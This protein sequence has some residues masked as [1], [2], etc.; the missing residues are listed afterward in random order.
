MDKCPHCGSRNI[1]RRYS[2]HR[3]YKWRCRNCNEV[4]RAPSRGVAIWIGVVAVVVVAAAVVLF[5]VQQGVIALPI[6]M[7]PSG[8]LA[9]GVVKTVAPT[10][11]PGVAATRTPERVVVQVAE[12][13]ATHTVR[14]VDTPIAQMKIA[15]TPTH[16]VMPIATD[17]LTPTPTNTLMP[18]VTL[19]PTATLTP[20]VTPSPTPSSTPTIT[21]TPP[22]PPPPHLRHIEEKRYM[23]ALINVERK[24]AGVPPV[25][26]GDNIAA[27]LHAESA[28]ENCFPSHWGIDGLKPYMRYSLAGGYQSNGENGVGGGTCIKASDGYAPLRSVKWG[29]DRSMNALV[30]SPDHLGNILHKH[31]RK[32]NL[33]I[34]YDRYNTAVIQHFEGDYVEYD[35]LP[36]ITD[37]AL[38]FSGKTKNGVRFYKKEDIGVVLYYD[39]SPHA[40]THEDVSRTY[41]YCFGLK[42]AAFLKPVPGG[43]N[44]P[45]A[46][47]DSRY[48]SCPGDPYGTTYGSVKG[49]Y[50]IAREWIADDTSFALEADVSNVLNK[51]GAGVYSVMVWGEIDGERAVISEYSIFHG[52]TPPDTY[53]PH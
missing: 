4:F 14:P 36:A 32:V 31:H 24:K 34:T 41:A 12:L 33:G 21:P 1:R 20:T 15:D 2:E 13:T 28:W 16:T 30:N 43:W 26:L 53:T 48:E 17:T 22:T 5:A 44:Y 7:V 6:T 52:I 10:T 46:E 45:T 23:L 11:P 40:L 27:Q 8:E 39:P 3:R 29:L 18:T 50:I 51:Y 19:T 37:G 47:F 9:G 35:N 25:E 49:A 42:V 38:S